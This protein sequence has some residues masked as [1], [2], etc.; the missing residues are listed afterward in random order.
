MQPPE[1]ERYHDFLNQTPDRTDHAAI[2]AELDKIAT[3]INALRASLAQVQNDDGALK[4]ASVT[5]SSLSQAVIDLMTGTSVLE[6]VG[7]KGDT[8]ASFN[9]DVKG[10]E[11]ERVNFAGREKGFSFFSIDT[12]NLYF[13][14]AATSGS[15]SSP[16]PFG[17]GP[18][19]ASAYQAWLSAGNAG[20]EAQFLA[21]LKGDQGDDGADGAFTTLDDSIKTVTLTGRAS[22]SLSLVNVGGQLQILAST[23]L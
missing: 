3:S 22:L 6:V 7:P 10:L 23:A 16:I 14:T 2:N 5:V 17:Q 19:G 20:T 21:S 8:G 11:L 13:K 9:A 18:T 4:P 15:W 1:Y 12:G